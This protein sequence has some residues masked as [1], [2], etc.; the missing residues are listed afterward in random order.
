MYAVVMA[1]AI[2]SQVWSLGPRTR[3][4]FHFRR[5]V[6]EAATYVQQPAVFQPYSSPSIYPYSTPYQYAPMQRTW[7]AAPVYQRQC[8]PS[9]CR[10]V[11]V[12]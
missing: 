4:P 1:V 10:M 3:T 7:S 2:C 6:P 5:P 12:R 11:R 8:G 9:G